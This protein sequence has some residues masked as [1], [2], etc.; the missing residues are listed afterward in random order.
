MFLD[1]RG[2]ENECLNFVVSDD[3]FHVGDLPDQLVSLDSVAEIAGSAGLEIRTD[4]VAQVLRFADVNDFSRRVF[5]EI[6][7]GCTRNFFEFFVKSHSL[8]GLAPARG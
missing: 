5:V 7:A 4:A 2:F 8:C 6:D 3:D 1:Q